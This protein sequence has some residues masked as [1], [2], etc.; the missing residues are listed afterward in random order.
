MNEKSFL[1]VFDTLELDEKIRGLLEQVVVTKVS[2]NR[3]QDVFR[4][5]ITSKK[6]IAKDQLFQLY[7][8]ISWRPFASLTSIPLRNCGTSMRKVC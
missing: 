2:T 1:E 6:L 7:R 8:S 3:K 4:I 5:Y